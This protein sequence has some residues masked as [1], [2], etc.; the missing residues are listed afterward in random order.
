MPQ[1]N[2]WEKEYRRPQLMTGRDLPQQDTLRFLKYI[3]KN[4]QIELENLKILDLGSGTGRNSNYLAELGNEVAGLEI[5]NT[6]IKIAQQRADEMNIRPKYLNY[7]IGAIYPF[8]DNYFDIILDVTS[9]NSLNQKERQ[10]YL[11][12]IYRVLKPNGHIFVRA[13][14]K[15][16][17]KNAKNLLKISPGPE[18]DTYYMKELDLIERVFSEEDFRK[19]YGEKFKI[20]FLE[21][22]K[23]YARLG[24][25]SYKRIYWIAYLRK[26]S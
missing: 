11:A 3:K 14:S 9:S 22:K 7:N 16:G 13:L 10:I 17:D 20:E 2:A 24:C 4:K 18:P 15:D 26:A 8:E 23:G 12:E 5:S 25:Q 6:A 1:Q 19:L 21:K